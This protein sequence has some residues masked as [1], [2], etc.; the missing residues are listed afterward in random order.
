[1]RPSKFFAGTVLALASATGA[2]A[3]W[4]PT[5]P[6]SF[7]QGQTYELFFEQPA[8]DYFLAADLT[9]RYS[10]LV[11]EPL[12]LL[13][14]SLSSFLSVFASVPT[15]AGGGLDELLIQ[16]SPDISQQF[17]I[18]LSLP[19]GSM[20]GVRFRVR[21]NAPLGA[22]AGD[23]FGEA[24]VTFA[25][26]LDPLAEITVPLSASVSTTILAVPEPRTWATMLAGLAL[27][28]GAA[29]AS[30]RKAAILAV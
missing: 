8:T 1:M 12:A 6:Y 27:L 29:W 14:G 30:R 24:L 2:H 4:S 19:A 20:F 3:D 9:V 16:V 15:S 17:D 11:Y 7:T 21:D 13:P 22:D 28:A 25:N 18:G 26:P 23:V 10:P 5:G